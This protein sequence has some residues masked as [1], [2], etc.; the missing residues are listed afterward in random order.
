MYGYDYRVANN[1]VDET[2][3]QTP[4]SMI[5]LMQNCSLF[6]LEATP[7]FKHYLDDN[8]IAMMIVSRQADI[9]RRPAFGEHVH[10][11]TSIYEFRGYLGYRNTFVYD[12]AGAAV[13]K[14]WAIGAFVSLRTGKLVRT[15]QEIVDTIPFAEKKEMEY[16]PKKIHLPK[17]PPLRQSPFKAARDDIDLYG[18]VN[19]AQYIRMAYEYLPVGFD[20]N[21]VRVEYKSQAKRGDV[22]YPLVFALPENAGIAVAL[23][24]EA[25]APYATIELAHVNTAHEQ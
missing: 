17:T 25:D 9:V 24:D 6:S 2:V 22:I 18:H 12:A 5:T 1:D 8:D 4:V 15:P 10:V 21:R 13:G 14:C 20:C 7:T 3:R 11:E 19:N 16:L 23:C